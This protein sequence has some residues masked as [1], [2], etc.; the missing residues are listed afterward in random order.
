MPHGYSRRDFIVTL[1]TGVASSSLSALAG[2]QF[3]E[4]GVLGHPGTLE[5]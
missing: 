3:L 4:A 1:G 2:A 5:R